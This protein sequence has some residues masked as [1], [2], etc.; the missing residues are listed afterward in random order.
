MITSETWYTQIVNTMDLDIPIIGAVYCFAVIIVGQFFLLN[1]ILAV[2]IEAFKKSHEL[3]LQ[4]AL[5]LLENEQAQYE[6]GSEEFDEE[7]YDQ[8]FDD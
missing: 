1:L 6:P 8:E 7:E 2:M 4:E 3:R 5:N